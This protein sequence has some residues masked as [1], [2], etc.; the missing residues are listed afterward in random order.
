[1]CWKLVDRTFRRFLSSHSFILKQIVSAVLL[2][3]TPK[4]LL[5]HVW[6][7]KTDYACFFLSESCEGLISWILK[8]GVVVCVCKR[9]ILG[10][11]FFYWR[12]MWRNSNSWR[13]HLIYFVKP[14]YL[15]GGQEIAKYFPGWPF[16]LTQK[17]YFTFLSVYPA[18]VYIYFSY[19]IWK[20]V[21]L[22]FRAKQESIAGIFCLKYI[23]LLFFR[24]ASP[25]GWYLCIY[26]APG[27][28]TMFTLGWVSRWVI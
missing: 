25:S 3:C 11:L 26:L 12:S 13:E 8:G 14:R 6:H 17:Y 1:M 4:K 27:V 20:E 24:S 5:T 23:L 19:W 10:L 16:H 15:L 28:Q 18:A 22:I 9:S 7:H 2:L 21:Q